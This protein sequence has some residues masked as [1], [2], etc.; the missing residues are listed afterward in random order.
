MSAD[1]EAEMEGR[2]IALELLFREFL[3]QRTVSNFDK[4]LAQAKRY[5]TDFLALLQHL[6]RGP[7]SERGDLIWEEASRAIRLSLD[8]VVNRIEGAQ[9]SGLVPPDAE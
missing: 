5:R 9:R 7:P 4:P 8:M 3:T 1:S 2:I 6:D